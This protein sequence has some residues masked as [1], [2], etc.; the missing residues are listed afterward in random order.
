MLSHR[1]PLIH[2]M[3]VFSTFVVRSYA[4]PTPTKRD[5]TKHTTAIAAGVAVPLGVIILA[6]VLFYFRQGL[7]ALVCQKR[8]SKKQIP[9]PDSPPPKPP[10]S[11]PTYP[12]QAYRAIHPPRA[13]ESLELATGREINEGP[14]MSPVSPTSPVS[15]LRN[16]PTSP[17]ER[18]MNAFNF[19][20]HQ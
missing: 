16:L 11:A 10:T 4:A 13:Q 12:K 9:V 17:S 19:S 20:L 6:A 1:L 14:M 2:M 8:P 5:S 18:A 3:I 15:P 7:A